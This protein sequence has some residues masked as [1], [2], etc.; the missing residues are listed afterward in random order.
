MTTHDALT[1]V[2]GI[3]V[4]DADHPEALTGCH[5]VMCRRGA[6]VGVDVRGS[7]PGTRETD[8]CRPGTLVTQAHAILLTGGSA[9]GLDAASGVM[10]WLWENNVG[11]DAGAIRVPIVPGAVIFDLGLVHHQ[12]P[13]A[14]MGYEACAAAGTGPIRQGSVGAGKGASVG[15]L[16]GLSGAMKSGVGTAS[17]RLGPF[18]VAALMVVNAF[19]DVVDATTGRIEAGARD[20]STGQF[21]DTARAL[22]AAGPF[23]A[24]TAVNTT[25][26]VVATDAR[27]DSSEVNYLARVAHDGLARSIRPVHTMFDGDTIFS[28]ATGSTQTVD[29]QQLVALGSATIGVVETAV[30]NAVRYAEAMGGLP[31]RGA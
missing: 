7:A 24:G 31:A 14:A 9:F 12:W 20:P 15:K 22:T 4:G 21:V 6:V 8:L 11:Y 18:T 27:L 30:F 28:L 26:G 19:G 23:P 2:E 1:D 25:I 16:F 5:V 17:A 3:E 29:T 10:R 13:D